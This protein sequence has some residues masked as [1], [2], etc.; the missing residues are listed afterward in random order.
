MEIPAELKRIGLIKF[1]ILASGLK[2]SKQ[3]W[4]HLIDAKKPIRTRSGASGGLDLILPHNIHVNCPITEHFSSISQLALDFEDELVIKRGQEILCTAK[5]QLAPKYYGLS[6]SDGAPMIKIGQMCSGDRF[7]YGMTGPYCFF[8]KPENRCRFCSIGLNKDH[9]ASQ[10]VI[11]QLLEALAVA[12]DDPFLPAKHVLIGGG[13]PNIEDMGASIAAELCEAIKKRFDISCYVMISAPLK[14]EYIDILLDA[15]ADELGMNIEFFSEEAWEKYI[16][17]KAKYIG[18]KRYFEALEYAVSRFGPINTRSILVVGLETPEDSINGAEKL[19]SM[20]VMPIFSPFRPLNGTVL[21]D[22]KGFDHQT[23]FDIFSE[24]Y[25]RTMQYGIPIG[26][27]CIPCQ[28]N[29]L[30]LP[31]PN[32]HYHFY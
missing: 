21:E 18:K 15:G 13:T 3:A 23:Y 2:I 7:C 12:I 19:A 16:P 29:T 6:T 1:E 10:K 11:S 8:W 14:N 30:A 22:E 4:Q 31:L 20:G 24:A 9:D 26:P 5:L 27:T 32:N 25:N 17:G 28:N